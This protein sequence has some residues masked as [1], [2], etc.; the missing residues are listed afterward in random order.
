MIDS[1]RIGATTYRVEENA[2]IRDDGAIGI[3]NTRTAEIFYAPAPKAVQAQTI[4]HEIL[5]AIFDDAGVDFE[6]EMEERLVGM[7]S[8]RVTAFIVD[9]P[10]AIHALWGMLGVAD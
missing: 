10:A 7:L 1:V 8:P 5:H 4:V 6:H 2:E 3:C 9:N